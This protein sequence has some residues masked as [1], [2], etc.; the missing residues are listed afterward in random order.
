LSTLPEAPEKTVP[1]ISPFEVKQKAD[2]FKSALV[3][4]GLVL[5]VDEILT[6]GKFDLLG[7]IAQGFIESLFG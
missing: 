6:D 7:G 2:E 4:I 1:L 5:A 3:V